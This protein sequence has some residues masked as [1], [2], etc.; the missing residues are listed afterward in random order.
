M[1]DPHAPSVWVRSVLP[2]P[3]ED[4]S[5]R[6]VHAAPVFDDTAVIVAAARGGVVACSPPAAPAVATT[7]LPPI[8]PGVNSNGNR[9]SAWWDKR[10][11]CVCARVC[12]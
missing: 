9:T 8:M 10:Y 7:A 12:V 6:K 5:H 3:E 2:A 11:Q 4:T 1:Y